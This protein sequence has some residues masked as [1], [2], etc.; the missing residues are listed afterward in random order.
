[1]LPADTNDLVA[2]R[3]PSRLFFSLQLVEH[4]A[5]PERTTVGHEIGWNGDV[6]VVVEFLNGWTRVRWLK[7][8]ADGVT[9]ESRDA[10]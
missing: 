5:V 2:E 3:V 8:R 6:N 7:W 9:A 4:N 1:M 10:G